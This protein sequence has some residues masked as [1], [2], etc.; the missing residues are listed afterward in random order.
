MSSMCGEEHAFELFHDVVDEGEQ[1]RS[2]IGR[3]CQPLL[4]AA[5]HYVDT[6]PHHDSTPFKADAHESQDFTFVHN[7]RNWYEALSVAS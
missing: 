3:L 7:P 2:C 6:E 4:E 1:E 5:D